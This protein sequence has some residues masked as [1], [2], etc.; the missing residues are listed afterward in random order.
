[1]LSGFSA[2]SL[3]ADQQKYLTYTVTYGDGATISTKDYLK[4]GQAKQ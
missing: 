3:T 2:T 1:M 4:K